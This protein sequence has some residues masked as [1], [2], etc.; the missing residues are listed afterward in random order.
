[1][2]TK[3]LWPEY[4]VPAVM[5]TCSVSRERPN[6]K[7]D[8]NMFV[9]TG[10][11]QSTKKVYYIHGHSSSNRGVVYYNDMKTTY[12]NRGGSNDWLIMCV[13]T[14]SPKPGNV[15]IDQLSI[16][17][18]DTGND[19]G[20]LG[21]NYKTSSDFDLHS[22][23]IWNAELS[24]PQMKVVT[25]ALRAQIGGKP[26]G[27]EVA[28]HPMIPALTAYEQMCPVEYNPNAATG[29]CELSACEAGQYR[30]DLVCTMCGAGTYS[31]GEGVADVRTCEKCVA[32]TYSTTEGATNINTCDSCPAGKY[33]TTEGA[34]NINTCVS[35]PNNTYSNE[36]GATVCSICEAGTVIGNTC[37]CFKGYGDEYGNNTCATCSVGTYKEDVGMVACMVCQQNQS[38]VDTGATASTDCGCAVGFGGFVEDGCTQCAA[39]TYKGTVESVECTPCPDNR[40]SMNGATVCD[41]IAGFEE[42]GGECVPC[43]EG[44][45]NEESLDGNCLPCPM[46]SNT[47]TLSI[48]SSLTDC[49]CNAGYG[50]D[51]DV[52]VCVVPTPSKARVRLNPVHYAQ[53]IQR[54]H[55]LEASIVVALTGTSHLKRI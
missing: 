28:V 51:S 47:D 8:V 39:G 38:T 37:S 33:S 26:D 4:S 16:G 13:K 15:I 24:T 29:D 48:H 44:T 5:T 17:T 36:T 30:L 35:C 12:E 7:G 32:G 22:V 54:C 23:Y 50:S 42:T 53:L 11:S 3:V 41:C 55:T 49:K 6:H 20:R 40:F 2:D 10:I 1:V 14:G 34:T 27:E 31:M 52:T 43:A 46:H 25:G 45:Y 18:A 19:A 9:L 21:V